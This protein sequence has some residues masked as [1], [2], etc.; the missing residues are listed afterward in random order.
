MRLGL[1]SAS[2]PN[3]SL[4][5]LVAACGRRGLAALELRQ[6]DGHEVTPGIEAPVQRVE[7]VLPSDGSVELVGYRCPLGSILQGEPGEDLVALVRTLGIPLLIEGG[8]TLEVRLETAQRFTRTGAEVRL[9]VSGPEAAE[10]AEIAL[11]QGLTLAWDVAPSD[12]LEC[13][14][15]RLGEHLGTSL[16]YI[17]IRGGGP[18]TTDEAGGGIGSLMG[19]LALAGFR[20]PVVLSPSSRRFRVIW[21]AW[22]GRR[23]GWGCGGAGPKEK[24][25]ILE[26]DA[27]NPEEEKTST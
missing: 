10:G 4:S 19:R 16:R 14:L 24:L 26:Q 22:L 2:L 21:E 12:E 25:T 23:G 17:R 6:G 1:S 13:D 27:V 15:D 11:E 18:E 5:E 3:A 9:V 20:G 8:E 7:T